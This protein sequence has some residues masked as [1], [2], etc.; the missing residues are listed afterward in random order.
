LNFLYSRGTLATIYYFTEADILLSWQT[1][2]RFSDQEWSFTDWT[3]KVRID[4]LHLQQALAF[5]H[6]FHQFGSVAVVPCIPSARNSTLQLWL[7]I[8]SFEHFLRW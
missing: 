7:W 5:D 8:G 1:F 4:K 2:R 6:H 3:S